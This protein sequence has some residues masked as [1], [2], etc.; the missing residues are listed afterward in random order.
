MN[1]TDS[2]LL[3][4]FV[5]EYYRQQRLQSCFC[6]IPATQCH[7]LNALGDAGGTLPQSDLT[8]YLGLEKSW[9]SRAV[10]SLASDGSL[11]KTKCCTDA[12]C[13]TL[14]L[15]EAGK[16]RYEELNAVLDAQAAEII[17]SIPASDRDTVRKSLKLLADALTKNSP[18]CTCGNMAGAV[19]IRQAENDDIDRI[20]SLLKSRHLP[21]ED[22][23]LDGP[24]CFVTA[25]SGSKTVGCAGFEAYGDCALLRSVAVAEKAAGCGTG[26]ALVA[27]VEKRIA[28]AG[29]QSVFLLTTDAVSFWNHSGYTVV[30]RDS[31]PPAIRNSF[32]Y[33][34]ACPRTAKLMNKQLGI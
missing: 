8:A 20:K 13:S 27:A 14:T 29:I 25:V 4:T 1:A 11:I 34:S 12:R 17:N 21:F 5:R 33:T 9:V 32:E 6:R 24:A 2:R 3:R 7:I 18:S 15:T 30:E 22:I 28:A 26:R 16:K 23:T 31:A 19:V 10:E